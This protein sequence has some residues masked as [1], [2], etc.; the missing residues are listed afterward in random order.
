MS[1]NF[2]NRIGGLIC[3]LL[4]GGLGWFA[5]YQPLQS[6]KTGAGVVEWVP[7][8]TILVSM[9][10]VYGIF[11][12]LTGD[13]YPYRNVEKQNFTAVG[14]VLFIIAAVLAGG[15]FYLVQ[16]ALHDMGYQH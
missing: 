6:A 5:I 16:K 7:K 2:R 14:W 4:A 3:L 8:V 1:Q 11:F 9:S 10:L 15:G 12:L 13:R